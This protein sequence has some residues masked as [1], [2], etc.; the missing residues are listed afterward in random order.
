LFKQKD[1]WD[2]KKH[3][4]SCVIGFFCYLYKK[5]YNVDYV[6]VPKNP[7]PYS[8]KECRDTW[9]MLATFKGNAHE[10]RKYIYWFFNK[11]LGSST[12]ITSFGYLN[13]PGI[14]RRYN[15][16]VEK[17]KTFTRSSRLPKEYTEWCQE[18]VPDIFDKYELGTMNDLGALLSHVKTYSDEIDS[19]SSEF[20]AVSHAV[21][22]KLIQDD[23]LN[24]R[25]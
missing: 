13:T 15:I 14:I 2:I 7:N 6:F 9:A 23:K 3:Q 21:K 20:R 24:I 12:N 17:K 10:A 11:H 1:N 8:A 18:Q 22:M 16:Y 19:E 4:V 25:G 5:K